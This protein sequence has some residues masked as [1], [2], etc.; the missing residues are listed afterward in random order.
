M[1]FE[2]TIKSLPM[3]NREKQLLLNISRQ[4]GGHMYASVCSILSVSSIK[5]KEIQKMNVAF[6]RRRLKNIKK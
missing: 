3:T 2:K 4:K 1:P 6:L 5:D